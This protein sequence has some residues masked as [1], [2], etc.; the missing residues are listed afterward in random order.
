M[1]SVKRVGCACGREVRWGLV[2]QRLK[3]VS[4]QARK[5]SVVCCSIASGVG[6]S[7]SSTILISEK[8]LDG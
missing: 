2:A 7:C 8:S 4:Y 3:D 5:G 6:C 1:W